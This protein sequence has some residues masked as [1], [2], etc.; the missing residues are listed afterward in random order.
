MKMKNNNIKQVI[1]NVWQGKLS[2]TKTFWLV[3][4]LGGTIVSLP[5]F[6]LTDE[7]IDSISGTGAMLGLVFFI[8]QYS[9]LI[10]AYVG[11]WRSATNYKPKKGQWSWGTIAKVY[12]ALNII[13]GIVK[14]FQ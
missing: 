13:R 9:Y 6:I 2:L 8:F 5:S 4:I 11:S 14:F 3:F 1:I 10:W 7:F 12:I